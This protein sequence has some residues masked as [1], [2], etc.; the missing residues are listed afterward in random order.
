MEQLSSVSL[1]RVGTSEGEVSGVAGNQ[2]SPSR[3]LPQSGAH[4]FAKCANEWGTRIVLATRR[5]V[6]PGYGSGGDETHTSQSA[7]CVGHPHAIVT[8]QSA[9]HDK[10]HG[11]S[12]IAAHPCKRRKD[13]A[14]SVG[15]GKGKTSALRRVGHPPVVD[16]VR[17]T[18]QL[19]EHPFVAS[20][21][22]LGGVCI[23]PAVS[24]F[25]PRPPLAT[26]E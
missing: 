24:L 20:R 26:S 13:G 22:H 16:N 18:L 11:T 15:Y 4:S 12:S 21:R 9:R 23:P 1:R 7:R 2:A 14:P 6:D 17:G 5:Y 8:V 10:P 3:T 19:R 25:P